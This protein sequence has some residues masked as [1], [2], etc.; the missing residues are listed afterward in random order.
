[1]A[2]YDFDL[3]VIGG[4]SGGVRCARIAAGHGARVGVAEGRHWGGTC[5]NVGCV[6]KK[7]MVQAAEYGQWIEDAAAFGWTGATKGEHD[8]SVLREARD[9]EVA[10]LSGLYRRMLEG[11]GATVFENNATFVDAHTLQVGEQR[12][13]AEKIVIAVGG[14]PI[15]PDLPGVECGLISDDLFTL[16]KRPERAVVIGGGYIGVEFACL[17]HGLGVDVRLTYRQKLPLRGFDQE[18]REALAEALA[19]NGIQVHAGQKIESLGA[20]GDGRIVTLASGQ[21]L[22]GDVVFLAVGREPATKNLG[23]EAAGVAVDDKG[24]VRVD[25]D[26][27]TSQAHIFAIGDVTDRVNLTPV[28]TAVGHAL[29]DTLFGGGPRHASFDN[30]PKA[31]FSAPPIGSVGLTEEEA[32]ERGPT[33]V[34]VTRFNPMRHTITKRAGR[35]ALMKLLVDAE[36]RVILGAHMLG[37]DAPE[38]L[39]GVAVAVVNGLTKEQFDRT[40]GIHPTAAEEFVTLRSPAR[41]VGD[42]QAAE[43]EEAA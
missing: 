27:R 38:I 42:P 13:T 22:E 9:R 23:L 6:P 18:I 39:Q 28:A 12:V 30:V 24:A 14:H 20:A 10:R 2:G 5:V 34:Y 11:A 33:E 32:A 31:V 4:G 36:T 15:R 7:I 21:L 16:E 25:A 17:L 3:F 43:T 40:I 19:A 26:Q 35:R 8:W 37:E 29:A 41:R 1:M